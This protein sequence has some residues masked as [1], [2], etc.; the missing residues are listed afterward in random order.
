[1]LQLEVN[2]YQSWNFLLWNIIFSSKC[3]EFILNHQGKNSKDYSCYFIVMVGWMY[4]WIIDVQSFLYLLA[5]YRVVHRRP[6][7]SVMSS[8][9]PILSS[10]PSDHFPKT[11]CH[12]ALLYHVNYAVLPESNFFSSIRDQHRSDFTLLLVT[13]LILIRNART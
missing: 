1:M 7:H 4:V 11:C 3:R 12:T 9:Q 6:V 13:R 5:H 8:N 2:F 10:I